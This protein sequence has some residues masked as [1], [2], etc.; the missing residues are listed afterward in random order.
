VYALCTIGFAIS[1]CTVA[2]GRYRSPPSVLYSRH[3]ESK[4]RTITFGPKGSYRLEHCLRFLERTVDD[5]SDERKEANDW[6]LFFVDAF[7]PHLDAAMASAAWAKGYVIMYHGGGTTGICQV[8]DTDCHG[9]LEK[10]YMNCEAQSFLDRQ[11]VDPSD[12]SR[13]RQEVSYG[14]SI[15]FETPYALEFRTQCCLPDRWLMMWLRLGWA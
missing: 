7:K 14:K 5:F 1:L 3:S 4:P 6:R 8:N 2:C 15:G 9:S 11:Y 10:E 12:I 13:S